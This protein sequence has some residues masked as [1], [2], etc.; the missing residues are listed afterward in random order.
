[1]NNMFKLDLDKSVTRLA[2]YE[3]GK[4]IFE[5][6]VKGE[7]DYSSNIIFVF[8]DNISKLASS[9]IQGFFGEIV[10]K[11]GIAGIENNVIIESSNA[12]LHNEII[13]NLL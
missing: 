3:Y 13:K 10:N 11:I 7:I 12:N 4:S 8:P 2:G 5:K 9:F 6:Q 1:M